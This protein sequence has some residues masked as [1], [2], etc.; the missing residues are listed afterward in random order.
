MKNKVI[1]LAVSLL[2]IIIG[3]VLSHPLLFR[4]CVDIY[5]FNGN[6]GC[7]DNTI[8]GMGDPLFVFSTYSLLVA[9]G[10]LFFTKPFFKTWARFA[11]WFVPLAL[12]LIFIL[13]ISSTGLFL[14][15]PWFQYFRADAA[16]DAGIAFVFLSLLV[17][18]LKFYQLRK[19]RLKKLFEE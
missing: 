1:P 12:V 10:V 5:Q 19:I 14:P 2:G 17:V 8:Q 9:L 15:S 13:P 6:L 7:G 3:Y 18:L 4:I 11:Y 16:R